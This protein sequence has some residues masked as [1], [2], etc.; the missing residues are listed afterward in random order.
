MDDSGRLGRQRDVTEM[1]VMSR[2]KPSN[3]AGLRVVG[4]LGREN[5]YMGG[6]LEM[7]GGE[8]GEREG[9][10]RGDIYREFTSHH[11]LTSH[12]PRRAF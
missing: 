12:R 6:K 8:G 5:T 9:G 10:E 4:R 7:S 1:N 11:V 2:Y 3:R